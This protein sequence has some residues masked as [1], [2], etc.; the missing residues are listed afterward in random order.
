[1]EIQLWQWLSVWAID[2]PIPLHPIILIPYPYDYMK[3]RFLFLVHYAVHKS[4]IVPEVC[5]LI[6]DDGVDL[7][8]KELEKCV[9]LTFKTVVF[10]K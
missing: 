8:D 9:T 6:I 7:G 2:Q 10:P 3:L 5:E 1:M 4:L